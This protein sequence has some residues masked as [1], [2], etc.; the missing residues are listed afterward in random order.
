MS[1]VFRVF[2][3]WHRIVAV[4]NWQYLDLTCVADLTNVNK[5]T[6]IYNE[7]S[8]SI[9]IHISN[10]AGCSHHMP[11][12][13]HHTF[14]TFVVRAERQTHYKRM[15]LF[16]EG[17]CVINKREEDISTESKLTAVS[18][19]S[20]GYC[21]QMLPLVK[22]RRFFFSLFLAPKRKLCKRNETQSQG[23]HF[24]FQNTSMDKT[25]G[26]KAVLKVQ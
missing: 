11:G 15:G 12:C 19:T 22:L 1:G 23:R 24:F 9:E 7:S 17:V 5:N 10:M 20:S 25:K 16:W 14:Q 2:L 3:I 18:Q 21:E 13:Q 4:K 8:F 6:W 26:S